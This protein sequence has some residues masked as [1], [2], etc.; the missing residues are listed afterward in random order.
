MRSLLTMSLT[1]LWL[2]LTAQV[3]SLRA[4]PLAPVRDGASVPVWLFD[5]DNFEFWRDAKGNYQ[6]YYPELIQEINKRY[7]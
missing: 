1:L 3:C 6:G 2:T 5:A 7:G 4:A